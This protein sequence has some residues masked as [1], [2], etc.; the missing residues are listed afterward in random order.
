MVVKFGFGVGV[1]GWSHQNVLRCRERFLT[2]GGRMDTRLS[3]VVGRR[4]AKLAVY[5]SLY[6]HDL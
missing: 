2:G 6:R 3:L 4:V 1:D 5:R